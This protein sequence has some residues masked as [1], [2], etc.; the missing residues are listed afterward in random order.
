MHAR[1]R[2]LARRHEH[3]AVLNGRSYSIVEDTN[4]SGEFDGGDE[5]LPGFPKTVPYTLSRNG[6]GNKITFNGKGL[7][8]G[9]RTIRV[10][11]DADA[12]YDCVK[13]S[14]SRIITG[15]YSGGECSAK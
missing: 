13:V 4:E 1:M 12:D 2:A 8:S 6:S 5:L 9:L 10:L 3:Y 7:I 15:R 14:M 11:S